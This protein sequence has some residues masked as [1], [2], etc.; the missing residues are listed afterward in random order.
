M[1]NDEM[2]QGW[3]NRETWAVNLHLSNDEG[4]YSQVNELAVAADRDPDELAEAIRN[5]VVD[6]LLNPDYYRTELGSAMPDTVIEL[7]REIGSLWRVDWD[8]IAK[9]WLSD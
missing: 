8:E 9:A 6:E 5:F 2:Y 1:S 4:L 3:A 7:S